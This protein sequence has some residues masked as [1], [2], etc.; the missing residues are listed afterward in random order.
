MADLPESH[1][2]RST[3]LDNLCDFV[4]S[5]STV[6]IDVVVVEG[7]PQLLLLRNDGEHKHAA[8]E[9]SKVDGTVVVFVE[10]L[11]Y[12]VDE[13]FCK[14]HVSSKR[15]HIRRIIKY[16]DRWRCYNW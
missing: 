6:A 7:R 12:F 16:A 9:L 14:L 8:H 10:R 11:E 1:G 15:S 5:Q 13:L 2:N 4:F 3:Y